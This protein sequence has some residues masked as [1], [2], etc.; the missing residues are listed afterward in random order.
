MKP[1]DPA[2]RAIE[3]R[4][5]VDPDPAPPGRRWQYLPLA[6]AGGAAVSAATWWWALTSRTGSGETVVAAYFLALPLSFTSLTL[7]TSIARDSGRTRALLL[8]YA[9]GSAVFVSL[10]A[11]ACFAIFF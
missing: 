11:Y 3:Y 4:G 10:I 2:P 9:L 8:A 7:A 6:F 1:D 5:P